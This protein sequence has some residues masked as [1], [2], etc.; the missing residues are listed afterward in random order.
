VIS[1]FILLHFFLHHFS[2]SKDFIS[3]LSMLIEFS[4]IR[5]A[6]GI[7]TGSFSATSTRTARAARAGARV[8]RLVRGV[9]FLRVASLA[10]AF[11]FR[12]KKQTGVK[13][14][15]ISVIGPQMARLITKK[16]VFRHFIVGFCHGNA[17]T[18]YFG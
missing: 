4:A 15:E 8:G 12:M 14:H 2:N 1:L 7:N 9:R 13:N 16:L 3:A 11:F 6:F 10:S 5:D 17:S 18:G